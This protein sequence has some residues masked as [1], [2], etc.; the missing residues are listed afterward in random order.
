[1]ETIESIVQSAMAICLAKIEKGDTDFVRME[2]DIM[3]AVTTRCENEN[4]SRR[5]LSGYGW[6]RTEAMPRIT[7]PK[8]LDVMQV[9]QVLCKAMYVKAVRPEDGGK[10]ELAVWD[11]CIY[12]RDT[13]RIKLNA[14][15]LNSKLS[16]TALNSVEERMLLLLEPVEPYSGTRYETYENG[17][18]D[19][20]SGT[21][22][23]LTPDIVFLSA[24]PERWEPP[25]MHEEG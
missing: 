14:L 5:A 4:Q 8:R 23:E 18:F 21:L 12:V 11:G 24:K 25:R 7:V 16:K 19:T 17:I 9:A 1:M 3:A 15:K 22:M 20:E 2:Q 10:P 6:S 13:R